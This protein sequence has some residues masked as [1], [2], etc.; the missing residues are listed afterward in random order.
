MLL[1]VLFTDFVDIGDDVLHELLGVGLLGLFLGILDRSDLLAGSLSLEGSLASGL[2]GL[3]LLGG[4]GLADGFIGVQL[5]HQ[6]P[7][8][9][10]VLLLNI[11]LHDILPYRPDHRLHFIAVDDPGQVTSAHAGA[12]QLVALLLEGLLGGG[13]EE[14]VQLLE[15]ALGPDYETAQLASGGQ[16]Q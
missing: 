8:L 9:Q 16:L 11:M 15:G 4:G 3:V 10:G 2:L 13:T 7:V 5:L 1:P 6:L 14:G 12:V